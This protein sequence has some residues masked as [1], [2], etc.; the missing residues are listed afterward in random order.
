MAAKRPR[1]TQKAFLLLRDYA[2]LQPIKR[3]QV[4]IRD[5]TAATEVRSAKTRYPLESR[6]DAES[7]RTRLPPM[8]GDCLLTDRST[9]RTRQRLP[10]LCHYEC[11]ERTG[12]PSMILRWQLE[13]GGGMLRSN[14]QRGLS[15][16]RN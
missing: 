12:L 3:I 13:R 5:W 14:C 1:K 8:P 2:K 9:R 16:L 15:R 7:V 11:R 10:E 6:R 4:L